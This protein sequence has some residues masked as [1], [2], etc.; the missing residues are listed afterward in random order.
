MHCGLETFRGFRRLMKSISRL[1][2]HILLAKLYL[3]Y[4]AEH[5]TKVLVYQS[6]SQS[7]LPLF[8]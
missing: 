5:I 7:S 1:A 6:Q 8:T 4:Q 2:L 3:L